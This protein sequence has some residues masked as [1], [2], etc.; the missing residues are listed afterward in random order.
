MYKKINFSIK[1]DISKTSHSICFLL[2]ML[3]FLL[4]ASAFG[5]VTSY[6]DATVGENEIYAYTSA[7]VPYGSSSHIN[8]VSLTITSPSGRTASVNTSGTSASTY[9]SIDL[10]DGNYYAS[11]TVSGTCYYSSY[12]H[13]IGGSGDVA[14]EDPFLRI[15][16]AVFDKNVI[17]ANSSSEVHI[18]VQASVGV[19]GVATVGITGG[20]SVPIGASYTIDQPPAETVTGGAPPTT[21]KGKV[22]NPSG[23]NS[24]KS[25]KVTAHF[26]TCPAANCKFKD[27]PKD[28]SNSLILQ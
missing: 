23:G 14:T 8:S 17:N 27:S 4:T 3:A 28:T 11:T 26:L 22:N 13:S 18:E 21:F 24:G 15:A 2:T 10:E 12:T 9:L 1:D 25:I 19:N 5:Q 16:S 20:A 7:S 6:T